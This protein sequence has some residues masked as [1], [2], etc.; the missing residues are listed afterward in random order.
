M[1][2]TNILDM[3]RLYSSYAC[4]Q[5]ININACVYIYIVLEIHRALWFIFSYACIKFMN[6]NASMYMYISMYDRCIY[7]VYLCMYI[8]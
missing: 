6:I 8:L 3:Y 4:I 1:Y 2:V 5:F 7:D